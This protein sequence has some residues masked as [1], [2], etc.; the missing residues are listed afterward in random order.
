MRAR[1][2]GA[3]VVG[4][5][6]GALLLGVGLWWSGSLRAIRAPWEPKPAAMVPV[7]L[8]AMLADASNLPHPE[9]PAV[10]PADS[11]QGS[12]G[13]TG[14]TGVRAATGFTGVTAATGT[15]GTADRMAPEPSL[16]IGVP[17]DSLDPRKIPDTF[18]DTRD[19]HR[20]EALDIM[21]ARGTPVH[22]VAEGNVAKLFNSKQG[23]LTVYQFDNTQSYCFYYAHL[24]RYAPGLKE[25]TL[26]RKGDVLGFVG[27][28]GNASPEGPHLHFAVFKLGP[29]KK[30]WTGTPIDPLPLM[31]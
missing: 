10:P 3:F 6:V 23:G 28:T 8:S 14:T 31:E 27:S 1:M 21:E 15:T 22:A 24:D 30:W 17:I 11:L 7:D 2:L 19:G 4:F 25:G 20:H 16:H 12:S 29:D 18:A 9:V 5:A 26:L 13:A